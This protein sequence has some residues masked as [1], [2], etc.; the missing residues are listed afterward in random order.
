MN[1][2]RSGF[3][4]HLDA[5]SIPFFFT[6]FPKNM[7]VSEMHTLFG[8]FGRIGEVYVPL[9]RDKRDRRFGFVKFKEVSNMDLLEASLEE[10]WWGECKLKVNRV[11]FGREKRRVGGRR[12][13]QVVAGRGGGMRGDAAKVVAG[14]SYKNATVGVQ[15]NKEERKSGLVVDPGQTM[16]EVLENCHVGILHVHREASTVQQC[17]RI[18]GMDGIS[19]LQMGK[20][21]VLLQS[22]VPGDVDRVRVQHQTWWSSVFKE[23]KTW[24]PNLVAKSRL[25]RLSFFGLP[26]HVWEEEVFKKLGVLF[27]EFIDFDEA[28]IGRKRFDRARILVAT[29]RM[30]L[31]QEN[32]WIK[33]MGEDFEILVV[34]EVGSISDFGQEGFREWEAVSSGGSGGQEVVGSVLGESADGY[35][36]SPRG[37]DGCPRFES[38]NVWRGQEVFLEDDKICMGKA[39]MENLWVLKALLRGFEMT[40]GFKVNFFKSCLIG[41][42]VDRDFMEIACNLL[43]CNEG[44]LPFTYLGLPVGA[45]LVCLSML[46]PL[47]EHVA[48]R[49]N[50]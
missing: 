5:T 2:K 50:S 7:L 46:E 34:E 30:V 4:K 24:K 41:I 39:T 37:Y 23:V 40:F 47:L 31:I 13:E 8:T 22:L 10:V 16:L 33:V 1:F 45:N 32:I 44:S 27:G 49:L 28:I 6:D 19:V 15:P 36:V 18:E 42:N 20:N 11:R 12:N 26:I 48:S 3:Q 9:K 29:D 17:L 35:D 25:V 14:V 43:N 38:T 21:M